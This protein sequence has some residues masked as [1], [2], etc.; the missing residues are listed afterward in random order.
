MS[1]QYT[2]GP[3]ISHKCPS[4]HGGYGFVIQSKETR[5][6]TIA[7]LFPGSSTDRIEPIAEANAHLIAAAPEL[8]GA[9]LQAVEWAEQ[10][11]EDMT[12]YGVK[13]LASWQDAI[14][15]ATG[16]NT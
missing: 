3:W 2:A 12:P 4:R 11:V 8:L 14:A 13:M 5:G 15:K 16:G 7:N 9:L 10:E 1:T 6:I